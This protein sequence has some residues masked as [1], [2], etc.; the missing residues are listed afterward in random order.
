MQ[1]GAANGRRREGKEQIYM[2][3]EYLARII[4]LKHRKRQGWPDKEGE[5]KVELESQEEVCV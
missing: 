4:R 5:I 1:T 2:C 3:T